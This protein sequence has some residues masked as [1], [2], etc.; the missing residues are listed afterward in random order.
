MYHE[1]VNNVNKKVDS[2][3]EYEVVNWISDLQDMLM[4]VN[5]QLEQ[6]DTYDFNSNYQLLEKQDNLQYC[7]ERL[8]E[9]LDDILAYK[10]N[11]IINYFD[12]LT[13]E[14]FNY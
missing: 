5:E 13:T 11:D 14:D 7:I 2:L 1:L 8:N 4:T 10:L 9:R 12:V 6:V 3:N